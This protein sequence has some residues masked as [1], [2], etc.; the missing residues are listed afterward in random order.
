M[1][2]PVKNAETYIPAL[3]KALLGQSLYNRCEIICI[4]SGST[5]GTVA[6]LQQYP[7][8]LVEIKPEEFN[9]GT[10]RNLGVGK[11]A[12]E[13]VVM[14]VQDAQPVDACWIEKLL[15][16]FDEERVVAV[17][18]Q[19]VVPHNRAMNPV[20]WFRPLDNGSIKKYS[21]P[22]AAAFDA[23]LP[24]EKKTICGWDNV[25]SCYRKSALIETPF[26]E[27]VF[28]EDA[29]WAMDALRKGYSIVYNTNARVY[30]YHHENFDFTFRRC[31]TEFYYRYIYFGYLPHTVKPG[32]ITK[33]RMIK[34]LMKEKI[35]VKEK[36]YWWKYN[37]NCYRAC[38]KAYD[39]FVAVVNNGKEAVDALHNKYCSRAPMS[40][41]KENA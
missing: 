37:M 25:T 3:M 34:T 38:I 7:V 29:I 22:S 12:G 35:P 19:Q 36:I 8:K 40:T 16:G 2:I 30:H 28:A 17:C 23:L 9:H 41:Q 33:A 27:V 20:Q 14:T 15:D 11:A 4:D 18:G 24:E 26:R 1:V 32:F 39:M 6:L 13:F 21:F 5:D 10:T 31:L